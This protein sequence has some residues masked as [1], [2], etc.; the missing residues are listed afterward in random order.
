MVGVSPGTEGWQTVHVNFIELA[1]PGSISI[2]FIHGGFQDQSFGC[3]MKTTFN[4]FI[5]T[6]D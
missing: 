3:Q 5:P 1:R 2:I 4:D 6:P